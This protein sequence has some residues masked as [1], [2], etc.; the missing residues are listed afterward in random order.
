M[1][2]ALGLVAF[3]CF[4]GLLALLQHCLEKR[5]AARDVR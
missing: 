3:A 5:V 4:I 1:I 2:R